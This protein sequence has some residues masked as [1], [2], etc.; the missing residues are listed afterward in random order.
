MDPVNTER[1]AEG[2]F[3]TWLLALHTSSLPS[4]GRLDIQLTL[5]FPLQLVIFEDVYFLY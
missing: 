2:C 1:D 4:I 5:G 3:W